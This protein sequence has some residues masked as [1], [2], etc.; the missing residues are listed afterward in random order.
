MSCELWSRKFAA[1]DAIWKSREAPAVSK[2]SAWRNQK[3]LLAQQTMYVCTSNTTNKGLF[4]KYI[5]HT[6]YECI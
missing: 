1:N 4:S 3:L 2:Q 6:P 5:L